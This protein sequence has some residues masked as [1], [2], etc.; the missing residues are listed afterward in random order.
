MNQQGLYMPKKAYFGQKFWYPH[1][2]KTTQAPC[3]YCF[4]VGHGTSWPKNANIWPKMTINACF[5]PNL[6][7]NPNFCGGSKSFGTL[8]TEKPLRHLVRIVFLVSYGTK[9]AKNANIW[10]KMPTPN[11]PKILL[12][13]VV[14]KSFGTHIKRKTTQAPCLHCFSVKHGT[15]LAK[16]TNIWP[17][18]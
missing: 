9:Q 16:K 12:F 8:I 2:G 15:K 14:S 1:N 6:A 3:S 11:L 17:T 5:G 4:L 7:E 10:P 13:M 18:M